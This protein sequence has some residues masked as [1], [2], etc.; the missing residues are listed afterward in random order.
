MIHPNAS[1]IKVKVSLW[2][3]RLPKLHVTFILH[4]NP[5]RQSSSYKTAPQ[6]LL[7][8]RDVSLN[9]LV[10]RKKSLSKGDPE[11]LRT[12]EG[13]MK[14]TLQHCLFSPASM[15]ELILLALSG[16][17]GLWGHTKYQEKLSKWVEIRYPPEATQPFPL[18]CFICIDCPPSS[19]TRDSSGS[20][21]Y[22]VVYH[23]FRC[24]RALSPSEKSKV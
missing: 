1:A 15:A 23:T 10:W 20:G 22:I 9:E 14:R 21:I 4:G 7:P 18:C 2:F 5:S 19:Q 16:N 11:D 13:K 8:F 17:W 6:S 3:F 24:I 12:S